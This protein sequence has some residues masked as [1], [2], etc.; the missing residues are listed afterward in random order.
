MQNSTTTQEAQ[1][2]LKEA[3]IDLNEK[4]VEEDEM[5]PCFRVYYDDAQELLNAQE[6]IEYISY[7]GGQRK[8]KVKR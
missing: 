3:S 5:D 6:N 4:E 7:R 1:T 2:E 8:T